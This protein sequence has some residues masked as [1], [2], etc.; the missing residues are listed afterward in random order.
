MA[1]DGG[2][3]FAVCD[4]DQL[5]L[6]VFVDR[7]CHLPFNGYQVVLMAIGI[8]GVPG[9]HLAPG[10]GLRLHRGEDVAVLDFAIGKCQETGA[11][12]GK[13]GSFGQIADAQGIAATGRDPKTLGAVLQHGSPSGL[14]V[15]D[16]S[17]DTDSA[18][19]IVHM[20]SPKHLIHG[21]QRKGIRACLGALENLYILKR[22][23][24][25]QNSC[26]LHLAVEDSRYNAVDLNFRVQQILGDEGLAAGN[27]RIDIATVNEQ[28]EVDAVEVP[29]GPHVRTADGGVDT[30]PHAIHFA[31][32]HLF[33]GGRHRHRQGAGVNADYAGAEH[34]RVEAVSRFS[35]H[36]HLIAGHKILERLGLDIDGFAAILH[37]KVDAGSGVVSNRGLKGYG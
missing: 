17:P 33:K 7:G 13:S 28:F 6:R 21:C 12:V 15:G 23:N 10:G 8:A 14:I 1:V 2:N 4:Q 32:D 25:E 22:G 34:V 9:G 26:Q 37:E 27:R 16:G 5:I 3:E 35:P 19:Q 36:Q 11:G 18:R 31:T 30:D 20:V 29:E 24:F